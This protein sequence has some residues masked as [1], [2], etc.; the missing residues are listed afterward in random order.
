MFAEDAQR[1]EVC[2]EV[3]FALDE[4]GWVGFVFRALRGVFVDALLE[5]EGRALQP[6][7]VD[8][9]FLEVRRVGVVRRVDVVQGAGFLCCYAAAK[10]APLF[11]VGVFVIG[12]WCGPVV[13]VIVVRGRRRARFKVVVFGGLVVGGGVVGELGGFVDFA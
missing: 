10:E 1:F 12:G 13:A 3:R 7:Q 11:V 5:F 8:L 9:F 2:V 4:L 6:R